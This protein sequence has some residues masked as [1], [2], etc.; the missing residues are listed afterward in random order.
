MIAFTKEQQEPSTTWQDNFLAM[1]P[2]IESRLRR[3]FRNFDPNS[4]EEA[5]RE[6]IAHCLF[7]FVR[8]H[9]RRRAHFA[10][11]F[12]LVL[13]STR[14]VRRGRPAAGRMNS[15]D[16]LSRY[17]QIGKG[18][19]MDSKAGEWIEELVEDQRA[20]VPELVAAKIDVGAWFASLSLR[21]KQV[22]RDMAFGWSTKELAAKHGV[23]AGRI[24]QMRRSLERSWKEFQ[25]EPMVGLA[26]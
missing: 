7:A 3:E 2:E 5:V 11:A 1:L 12:T 23:T 16:P 20:P 9:D 24:S 13:Y 15:K 18:I 21:M 19:R 8:M 6:G 4:R 25:G 10:T 14:H 17:A 26:W 22:A